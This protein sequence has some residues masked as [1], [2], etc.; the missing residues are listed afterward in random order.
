MKL[1]LGCGLK[2][3]I[4]PGWI[5]IDA[6]PQC[7]GVEYDNVMTLANHHSL[8]GLVDEIRCIHVIEH[9]PRP[10][11]FTKPNAETALKLWRTM[12]R[13]GGRLI[14]ECPDLDAVLRIYVAHPAS[15]LKR[16]IFG[17]GRWDGDEHQWGYG[18]SELS[19]L[20][21][22]CGFRI[23]YVGEGQDE[24][25]AWCPCVRVEGVK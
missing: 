16:V 5:N 11:G 9:L 15:R 12:L 4:A 23:V 21:A 20:M 22:Y 6:V 1:N 17:L 8:T 7:P 2:P 24:D 19:D 25:Q 3:I 10:F 18:R 14:V 13:D